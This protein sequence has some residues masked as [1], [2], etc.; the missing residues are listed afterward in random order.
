MD[1]KE[2]MQ[3]LIA[4]MARPSR[5]IIT[6]NGDDLHVEMNISELVAIHKLMNV[7]VS[8]AEQLI[9]QGLTTIE[10]AKKLLA[11]MSDM[12][13]V[14]VADP[15]YYSTKRTAISMNRDAALWQAGK[16]GETK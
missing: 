11:M 2:F 13:D 12:L 4:E 3:E 14:A 8:V 9:R 7:T 15:D 16:E 5:I 1:D 10:G 6:S